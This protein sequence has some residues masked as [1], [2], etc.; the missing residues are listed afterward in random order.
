MI[1]S[2]LKLNP[3]AATFKSETNTSVTQPFEVICGGVF[4]P[5]IGPAKIGDAVLGPS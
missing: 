3:S 1:V 2:Q 5:E 4:A